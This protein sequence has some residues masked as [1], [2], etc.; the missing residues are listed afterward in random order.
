[1]LCWRDISPPAIAARFVAACF[2]LFALT[3][4]VSAADRL[5]VFCASSLTDVMSEIGRDFQKQSGVE[6]TFSFAGTGQLARQIEAGAPA[7]ILVSADQRWTDWMLEK[8]LVARG[9]VKEFAGNRLVVAVKQEVENWADIEG[10]LTSSR[11]A[12]GEPESV[13]AGDYA[14]QALQKQG[15]WEKAKAQ[16]VYGENVRVA[17]RRLAFGEVSSAVVYATDVTAELGL[18]TLYTFPENSHDAIIYSAA[19]AKGSNAAAG[20][21]VAYLA[22][23][24]AKMVLKKFGFTLSGTTD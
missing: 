20:D 1:V 22:S 21:F 7:D 9:K 8:G 23:D 11:F 18:R 6:I 14:V 5:I 12:M 15:I 24:E 16:A 19:P 2:S 17:L 4:P 13:P 10:L 3:L